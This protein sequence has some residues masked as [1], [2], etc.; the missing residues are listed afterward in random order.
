MSADKNEPATRAVHLGRRPHEFLGAVNTPVFRATTMLFPTVA[1]LEQAARGEYAGIGLRTARPADRHRPAGRGRGDRGRARGARGAVG[2]HGDDAAAAGAAARR[3]SSA[4]HRRRLRAD[5]ALLQQPP[6]APGHRG[7]LLRSAAGCGDRARIPAE[8]AR[9]VHRV[10]GLADVLRAGHSGD[11]RGGAPAR[12]ARDH[13]Q[14]VGDAVRLSLVRPRRRR[15]GPCRHQ[16][17]R[18]AFGRAARAHPRQRGDV[19]AAASALDGHGRHGIAGRL[20]PRAAR[21]AHAAAAPGPPCRERDDDC[22]VAARRG[23]RCAR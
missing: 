10:A 21:P 4:R 13:R 16:V 9:R 3:R 6:D 1:D 22:A 14:F 17:H 2:S 19:P 20:L 15:V 12:R 18:R 7:E 11:R 23:P 8:H 5:A